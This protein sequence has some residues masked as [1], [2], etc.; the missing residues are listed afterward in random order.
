MKYIEPECTLYRVNQNTYNGA[1]T[2]NYTLKQRSGEG[3]EGKIRN[4]LKGFIAVY[5]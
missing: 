1:E 2:R 3:G 4:L 5:E